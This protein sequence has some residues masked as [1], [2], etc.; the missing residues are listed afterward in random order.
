MRH[1]RIMRGGLGILVSGWILGSLG[2]THNYYY[3]TPAC[4]PAV[5]AGVVA[6]GAVCEVPPTQVDGGSAVV[7]QGP[8][9]STIGGAPILSGTMPP[10]VVVSQPLLGRPL[11]GRWRSADPEASM[12][13]THVEGG[14]DDTTTNR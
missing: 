5:P 4:G 12:A 11:F 6:N 7:A 9:R 13:S 3:G 14:Y 8:T 1:A 2:C 10:R